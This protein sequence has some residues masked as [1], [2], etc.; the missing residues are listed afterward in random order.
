MVENPVSRRLLLGLFGTGSVVAAAQSSAQTAVDRQASGPGTPIGSA[1][2]RAFL[3]RQPADV[4]STW[5]LDEEER[6]G[7]WTFK[8]GDF[9]SAVSADRL[10]GLFLPH[11]GVSPSRGAWVRQ[12]DN[13]TG[14]A[15]WFGA[16]RNVPNFDNQPAI[17]AALDLCPVV[18]LGAGSYFVA[19]RLTITRNGTQLRG[20]NP[21]Q[22]DQGTS[23]RSTR[24][25]STSATETILQIGS[26]SR[27]KPSELVE[28]VRI[29]GFTVDRSANPFTPASGV[30]GCVGIALRWCVNCHAE[31]VFSINSSRG[32]T[33]SG[34][35]ENYIRYCSALREREGSNAS[36][37]CFIG[38]HFEGDAP[39]G[40]NGANA[41]LYL[42]FCRA[43]PLT[44]DGA[45][46]LTYGAGIRFDG[47]WV[48][49]FIK[50]FEA[51]S[52]IQYG[53]HG[54]GDGYAS[55]SFRTENLMI[56]D[57]VLD[58]SGTAC[59]ALEK[60]G[61]MTAVTI[62]NNYFATGTG[63]AVFLHQLGGSIT[64]A[65][66]Q[67]I[68]G[69]YGATGLSAVQVNNLRTQGNIYT[70]L[71]QPVI[72]QGVTH[73]EIA[74]TINGTRSGGDHP[75]ITLAECRNGTVDSIVSGSPASY[76]AGVAMKG[77]ANQLIEVNATKLSSSALARGAVAKITYNDQ[78][79]TAA[80]L[81]GRDC[82]ATGILR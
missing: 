53:I 49:L 52:G 31:R 34:T 28:A 73:F 27:S 51:G 13:V 71:R 36:N 63:T 56:T 7:A 75:A 74:D 39:S 29:E 6:A 26:D 38:F 8:A 18:Q 11:A 60:G 61:Q 23:D 46:S 72:L 1:D 40:Y 64:V 2:S 62:A 77:P 47:G 50:G 70:S 10:Q 45:P 37:D 15:E 16:R 5:W 48:D 59:I 30:A 14:R 82:L 80:G 54:I 66:N 81:F 3:E 4:G 42:T 22:T 17:Q 65:N 69:Q 78:S 12:W 25:V 21:T 24:I 68:V 19:R 76:T 79:I 58:H 20:V 35:V 44:T 32:F 33:F 41:S 9:A 43:F 67:F 57:C 55:T